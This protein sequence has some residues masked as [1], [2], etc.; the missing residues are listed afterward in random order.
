M[1]IYNQQYLLS[2]LGRQHLDV[3]LRQALLDRQP[4]PGVH[5]HV[6]LTKRRWVFI[7]IVRRHQHRP[8]RGF[9]PPKRRRRGY[10]C[11]CTQYRPSHKKSK[12][13]NKREPDLFLQIS[14]KCS[15]RG[16]LLN[17]LHK[18]VDSLSLAGLGPTPLLRVYVQ[19]VPTATFLV[20]SLQVMRDGVPQ[21]V[22]VP[23]PFAY[24]YYS[25]SGEGGEEPA[26]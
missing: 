6:H 21:L 7:D 3:K 11:A 10:V 25:C 2:S 8:V 9:P 26:M 14:R 23:I 20:I 19:Y 13:H 22:V 4:L 15:A 12:T 18:K 17:S 24:W 1:C 5:E 16:S